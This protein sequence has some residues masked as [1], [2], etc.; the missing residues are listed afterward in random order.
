LTASAILMMA[1][2][3]MVRLLHEHHAMSDRF[4]AHMLARNLRIEEARLDHVFSSSEQRLARTL[5]RLA[6]EGTPD[7]PAGVLPTMSQATLAEMVGTTRSRINFFLNKFRAVGC[8]EY[9]GGRPL[10]IHRERLAV[11][12]RE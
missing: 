9:A 6:G 3:Q 11:V 8:I 4:I 12:A 7:T 2:A 5:L 10:R 1:K